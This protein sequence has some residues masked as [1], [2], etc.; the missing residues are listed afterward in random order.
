MRLPARR[1]YSCSARPSP[2]WIF[3]T[4]A[5]E[6]RRRGCWRRSAPTV[7][8]ARPPGPWRHIV[9]GAEGVARL[10]AV[11]PNCTSLTHLGLDHTA[12]GGEG[13]QRMAAMR[14]ELNEAKS[15][16]E[17]R[18][19]PEAAPEEVERAWAQVAALQAQLDVCP[20][21]SEEAIGEYKEL[22]RRTSALQHRHEEL[23]TMRA[24]TV[25]VCTG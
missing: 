16:A 3:K 12:I 15:R 11:L 10:A 6:L 24:K 22:Q 7:Q 21:A 2:T 14:L 18:P 25:Q 1:W 9:I 20:P 4:T 5:S 17:E 19:A 8:V 23:T 13:M